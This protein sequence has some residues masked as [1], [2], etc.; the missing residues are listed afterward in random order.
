MSSNGS[1]LFDITERR[2]CIVVNTTDKCCGTI[3]RSRIRN[4]KKE[5]SILDFVIVNQKVAPYVKSMV[6][7]E[8]KE[9]VLTRYTKKKKII[10]DHNIITCSLSIP[11]TKPPKQRVE[12]YSLRN[13]DTECLRLSA[14]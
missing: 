5:E 3:T 6:I 1:I 8:T 7:D 10:S 2:N 14:G 4:N 12:V 9:K 11:H 13:K